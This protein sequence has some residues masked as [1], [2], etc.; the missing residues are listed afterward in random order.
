VE[1]GSA[2]PVITRLDNNTVKVQKEGETDVISFDKNTKFP[3]T[4][5]IDIEAFRQTISFKD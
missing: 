1:P 3:A 5:V 2:D 4:L